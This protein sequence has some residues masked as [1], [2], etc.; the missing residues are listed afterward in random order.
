MSSNIKT[1]LKSAM[2]VTVLSAAVYAVLPKQL[3]ITESLPLSHAKAS[4]NLTIVGQWA[5]VVG[6]NNW[7]AVYVNLTT[8][9]QSLNY[10]GQV[11]FSRFANA[12]L[13]A[14]PGFELRTVMQDIS[15]VSANDWLSGTP[16]SSLGNHEWYEFDLSTISIW[17]IQP[18]TVLVGNPSGALYALKLNNFSDIQQRVINGETQMKADAIIEIK[19]L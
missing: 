19:A 5:S 6:V 18:I 8:G 3:P 11:V 17:P 1:I 2:V 16:V 12:T 7:P 14:N 4:N 9:S 13:S 10:N 15:S